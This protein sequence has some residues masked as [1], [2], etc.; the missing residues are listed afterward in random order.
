LLSTYDVERRPVGELS[1]E[2]A[3]TRYVLRLAPELGKDNLQPIVPEYVVELGYRYRSAA[4]LSERGD[5]G[6]L[7]ED[8]HEPSGAPGFRAPHVDLERD[9]VAVSTLD[10]GEGGFVLFAGADGGEWCGPARSAADVLGAGLET[11]RVAGDGELVDRGGRFQ[12]VY[13][14]GGDGAVLLRPDGFVA[15]RAR[16][17]EGDPEK[18]V[19]RALAQVLARPVPSA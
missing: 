17:R 4:V 11:F 1:V 15:W 10:V 16:S 8:P 3:Y 2:Q 12:Q 9:G 18:A 6:P 7:H 19:G 13:G 14:I 5:D